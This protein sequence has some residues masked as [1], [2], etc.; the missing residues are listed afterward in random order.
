MRPPMRNHFGRTVAV[1]AVFQLLL[2]PTTAAALAGSA[3]KYSGTQRRHAPVI[4]QMGGDA[5]KDLALSFLKQEAEEEARKEAARKRAEEALA[6]DAHLKVQAGDFT[7]AMFKCVA[8]D[9]DE[10][11]AEDSEFSLLNIPRL[12]DSDLAATFHAARSHS[13]AKRPKDKDTPHFTAKAGTTN[14][15]I[16][17]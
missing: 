4:S 1:L 3:I 11:G 12:T 2:A 7:K 15:I 9:D 8:K 6:H 13:S 17:S 14:L 10:M 5:L 16:G